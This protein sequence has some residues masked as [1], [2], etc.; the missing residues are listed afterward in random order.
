MATANVNGVRLF[1]EITGT[2]EIPLV[3]VHGSWVSHHSW[4]LV[5]PRLA[6]SFR[7]LAYD[8]RG[9]SESQR[10]TVQGSIREDV[11]D[12]A[13]LIEHLGLAPAWVAGNSFGA[14][15]TL[16]LAGQRPDLFRGL[17][18]HEPTLVSLLAEDPA[19][20]PMLEEI[21][22]RITAVVE[23]IASGDYAGAAEQFVE[24]VAL[25][26]G[27][28][29]QLPP[30]FQQ[31]L[32]ENA[33]TFLDEANDPEHFDFDLQWIKA[34]P[35]PALLTTG[36]QSPPTFAPV[37]AKLAQFLP[38]AEVVTFSGAGHIPHVTHPDVYVEAITRFTRKHQV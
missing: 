19:M 26:P 37:V 5:V 24:T 34:F 33:P 7:V 17:I 11:A 3:L 38:H 9:H 2:G 23:R 35:R 25:G 13:A 30:E 16:W 31:T 21:G 29:V 22:R 8:R 32:V 4:D 28:W 10:L 18:A 20:A 36:G 12:L 14:S 27:S 1:Y 6:R 15:T